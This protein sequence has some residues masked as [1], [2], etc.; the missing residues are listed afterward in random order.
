MGIPTRAARLAH[1]E[2]HCPLWNAGEREAWVESWR[3]IAD[4]PLY[5]YDPVGKLATRSLIGSYTGDE[6]DDEYM[7]EWEDQGVVRDFRVAVTESPK[8]IS[9]SAIALATL[10][11]ANETRWGR[12]V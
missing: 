2:K 12:T 4:G 11:I 7:L 3:T 9:L 10:S 6:D 1:A 5:M 8:R